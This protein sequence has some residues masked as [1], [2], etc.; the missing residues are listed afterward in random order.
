VPGLDE[1]VVQVGAA[2]RAHG[3]EPGA[4]GRERRLR[5][6]HRLR[7]CSA[8]VVAVVDELDALAVAERLE[9]LQGRGLGLFELP[10]RHAA[11]AVEHERHFA[12]ERLLALCLGRARE[13][14]EVA[15]AD[16]GVGVGEQRRRR[17]RRI[18][19]DRV[20]EPEGAG[21]A[22]AALADRQPQLLLGLLVRVDLVARRVADADRAAR[23][24]R[25]RDRPRRLEAEHLAA[26]Q[27][28]VDAVAVDLEHVVVGQAHALAAT[29]G[30]R[31]HA[32]AHAAEAG[33][34]EQGRVAQPR[35]DLVVE[36]ARL[37]ERQHARRRL[38]RGAFEREVR[39]GRTIGHRQQKHGLG[40]AAA[41]VVQ[42]DLDR[43]RR[44]AVDDAHVGRGPRDAHGRGAGR[45]QDR[46]AGHDP[47]L[48]VGPR[49]RVLGR[50]FLVQ[51]RCGE[52]ER[53]P[54]AEGGRGC[55]LVML[56]GVTSSSFDVDPVDGR[57]VVSW[58]SA[59]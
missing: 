8:D 36:P 25:R 52:T 19:G 26:R 42:F 35:R 16:R 15:A 45:R 38:T 54:E 20:A 50:Q 29:R 1:R 51:R 28:V 22:L 46:A 31:E 32:R 37:V 44:G 27:H 56:H 34:L 49:L 12:H 24:D 5:L 48:T 6:R 11:R 33:E 3:V 23:L 43:R 18:G 4:R 40:L 53:G 2:V 30:H 21:V 13:Q 57:T 10:A 17:G 9:H 47:V 55:L 59:P 14:Q 58:V 7:E 39:D 41:V